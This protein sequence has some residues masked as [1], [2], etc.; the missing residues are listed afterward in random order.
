M[1]KIIVPMFLIGML[2]VS[3]GM[4]ISSIKGEY[5]TNEYIPIKLDGCPNNVT[6]QEAWDLLTDIGNGIQIPVDVRTEGEWNLG[7]IDTPWPECPIWYTMEL[8]GN[9][10][11]L[12]EFLENYDGQD[13]LLYCGNS[14]RS[15]AVSLI[16]CDAGFT[17]TVYNMKG[18]ISAWKGAGYPI[19]NNTKPDAPTIDGPTTV[20]VKQQIDYTFS[21]IDAENDVIYYWINWSGK[22]NSV[23]WQGPYAS[24]ENVTFNHTFQKK[25]KYIIKAKVKD[26]YD[27]ES[28][29]MEYEVTVPR[30]KV[31]DF[32]LEWLCER[33]PHI[34]PFF[35]YLMGL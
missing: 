35:R 19:R 9:E 26:F 28:D 6:V 2:L 14:H 7:Y 30:T 24:G 33:F 31:V 32:N 18:G 21:A 23:I 15:Y 10:T 25:G 22:G 27:Y 4:S 5:V 3:Y 13:I 20:K 8:F 1:K 12:Q 16:L 11:G 34:F 29:W 17:G